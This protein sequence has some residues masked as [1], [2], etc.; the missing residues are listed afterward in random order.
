MGAVHAYVGMG[1]KVNVELHLTTPSDRAWRSIPR[2]T[3]DQSESEPRMPLVMSIRNSRSRF[4]GV[5]SSCRAGADTTY[6]GS[7]EALRYHRGEAI[8]RLFSERVR[9]GRAL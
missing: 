6:S 7:I 3:A 5:R 2:K 4:A 8:D 1:L 9:Y